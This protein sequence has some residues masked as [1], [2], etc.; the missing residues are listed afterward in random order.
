MLNK[1][2]S[3]IV[4]LPLLISIAGFCANVNAE[5]NDWQDGLAVN[6]YYT[7]GVTY[8]DSDLPVVSNGNVLRVLEEDELTFKNSIAGMQLRYD[9]TRALSFF[10]QGS[11]LFDSNDDFDSSLDWAYF[12]YDMGYDVTVRAGRF[13]I[14]FLQGTE[15]KSIGYSRLWA[16]PLVPNAGAGGYKDYDGLEFL[17]KVVFE[18]SNLNFQMA[19]GEPRHNIDFIDGKLLGLVSLGYEARSYWLRA[20]LLQIDYEISTASNLLID[21]HA[22]AVMAS[23]EAE[24]Q[25]K[26]IIVNGGFSDSSTDITPDSNMAYLSLAYQAS[27]RFTPYILRKVARQKFS[28]FRVPRSPPI[29]GGLPPPPAEGGPGQREGNSDTDSFALG[30]RYDF[31]GSY[32]LKVQWEH[33]KTEDDSRTSLGTVNN[34]GDVLSVFVEGVF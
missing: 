18:N 14:P 25:Y 20:A 8:S 7:L 11:A 19:I 10:V 24:Y 13:Q 29:G 32:A 21:D 15:L 33:V 31:E 4:C 12:S 9:F 3:L 22:R 23:I 27:S 2:F 5:E 17:K 26:K 6:A 1:V 16:N 34:R 30:F 28:R